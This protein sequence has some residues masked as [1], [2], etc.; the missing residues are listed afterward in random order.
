MSYMTSIPVLYVDLPIFHARCAITYF[1][2]CWTRILSYNDIAFTSAL[3]DSDSL[4]LWYCL[5][6]CPYGLV[7]SHAVIFSLLLSFR[8]HSLMQWYCHLSCPLGLA[9]SHAV[10]FPLLLSLGLAFSHAVTFPSLL[11]FR[12]RILSC[13]EISLAPFLRSCILSCCDISLTSVL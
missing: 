7:F 9:F 3:Q 12:T 6:S 10:I 5:H 2:S 8:S 4:V 13:C 1:L 11:S